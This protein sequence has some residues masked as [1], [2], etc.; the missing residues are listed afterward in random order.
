MKWKE[1]TFGA[2][3]MLKALTTANAHRKAKAF[4]LAA[5]QKKQKL[6]YPDWAQ[7]WMHKYKE[8]WYI[9]QA[10]GD[11][12][13]MRKAQKLA[14]GLRS[15][16]R[17]MATF[18]KWAQ[19]QM[20]KETVRWMTAEASGNIMEKLAA[21]KAGRALREKLGLIDPNPNPNPE[22]PKEDD[23][24]PVQ[25]PPDNSGNDSFEAE[26]AKFPE[27][28]RSALLKLHK[29]HPSWRFIAE[30]TNVDFNSFLKAEMKNGLVCTE[31]SKYGYSPPWRDSK[32]KYDNDYNAASPKAVSYFLDPRNFLTESRVFQFLSGKYDKSTQNKEAV[33]KVL[34]KS[35]ANK[36]DVFL[37]AG[38]NEASAVFL[39]AKA[40]V[41]SG[42]GTSTLGRGQ[43]PGYMGWYN[44]YGIGA[45]DGN[46]RIKGA[47]KAKS[48]NWNS[49]DS[50]II[51]G[52]KWINENY[53][54]KG[55]DTL[56]SLKWN[57]N[58]FKKNGT[59]S[60]QYAT[61]IM[62]AYTKADRFSKGLKTVDAPL[63]FRIPIYK[64][65]LDTAFPEPTQPLSR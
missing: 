56:Y 55:Q 32:L 5:E 42:G 3:P 33:N 63:S 27:S 19:E 15:K 17:E 65:M 46:A 10:N 45:N 44:M 54:Q 36:G 43:V 18:P 34:S 13:G 37:K 4:D 31:V 16:L 64:N 25:V 61:N 60:K 48:E 47:K 40:M 59:I 28:Y 62:D 2:T 14:E 41:E 24:K 50:A 38:G 58:S 52:G 21:E 9:A 11:E 12:V 53:I 26:L 30:E 49:V 1:P 39:A 7:T 6:N 22:V 51:G 20:Q 8:D 29:Q 35:L 23:S 57:V